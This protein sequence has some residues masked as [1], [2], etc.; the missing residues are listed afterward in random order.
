M[1]EFLNY[2]PIKG[3]VGEALLKFAPLF[4]LMLLLVLAV[5]AITRE[6]NKR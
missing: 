6:M 2:V 1:I 4:L 5:Y 3:S